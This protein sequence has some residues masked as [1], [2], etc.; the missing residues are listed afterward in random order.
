MVL[1]VSAPD[2]PPAQWADRPLT[3]ISAIRYKSGHEVT[4]ET[5]SYAMP[6]PIVRGEALPSPH[7]MAKLM[8]IASTAS[9]PSMKTQEDLVTHRTAPLATPTALG[10]DARRDIAAE[11]NALLADTF[12]LYAK[13][14]NFH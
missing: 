9:R 2:H 6:E 13:T 11:L 8:P 4:F 7:G 12:A 14:K 1:Q 10:A 5:A 3:R